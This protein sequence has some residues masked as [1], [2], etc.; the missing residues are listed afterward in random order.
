MWWKNVK[1]ALIIG[2]V[3]VI[4]ILI[5]LFISCGIDFSEC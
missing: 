4:V 3:I 2:A 5:I 1:M